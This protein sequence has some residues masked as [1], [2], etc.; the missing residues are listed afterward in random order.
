MGNHK[1]NCEFCYKKTPLRVIVTHRGY[2]CDTGCCGH[3]VEVNGEELHRSFDFSHPYDAYGLEG[4]EKKQA[5]KDYVREM[6]TN[7]MG[8]E[9]CKDIDWDNCIVSED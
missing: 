3:A 1:D 2:G 4:E 5:I 6:V 7:A 8:K 9:H